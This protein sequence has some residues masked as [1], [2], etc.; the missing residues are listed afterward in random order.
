MTNNSN[1][2]INSTNNTCTIYYNINKTNSKTTNNDNH[3]M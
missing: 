2:N 3:I 1:N